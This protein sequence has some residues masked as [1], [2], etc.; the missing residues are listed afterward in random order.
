MSW[1][2]WLA[3]G[4]AR[5]DLRDMVQ[6]LGIPVHRCLIFNVILTLILICKRILTTA[7]LHHLLH[8]LPIY[9]RF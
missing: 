5:V 7:I 8:R 3:C 1:F 9:L 4:E 6:D 2:V